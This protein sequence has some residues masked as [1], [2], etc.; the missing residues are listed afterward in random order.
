MVA[1]AL[2][3]AGCRKFSVASVEEGVELREAGV[4]GEI[5]VLLGAL[6]GEEEEATARSL[7][8]LLH[9]RE[10]VERWRAH[11]RLT[12]R[13]LPCHVKV[14]TGMNRAGLNFDD[15]DDIADVLASAP[16]IDVRGLATHMASSEDFD[17][18]AAAE[19]EKR[20][21]V[22]VAALEARGLRPPTAHMANSAAAVWRPSTR[23]DMVRSGLALYGYVGPRTPP[24]E[25]PQAKFE[26]ALEWRAKVL[27]VR[28]VAAGD[29]LGYSGVYTAT[30]PGRIA[31]ISAGY[32]DG[33]RRELSGAGAVSVGGVRRPMRG[34]V[35][36][37]SVLADVSEPPG[38]HAGDAA[39]LLGDG[40]DAVAL[41]EIC[42]TIPYEILCGI[43][44]RVARIHS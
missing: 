12:G 10:L 41:A 38:V 43:S 40:L 22:L 25:K 14:N 44:S 30:A 4:E 34:R 42:G 15:P 36:M 29:R 2:Q 27:D 5:L 21:A 24:S 8:P 13:R 39:V 1:R 33:L 23:Y 18:P 31:L 16:E 28:D 17:D 37:D 32:A 3:R 19:Q 20:F 26:P 7:T 6:P 35:S 9:S 11:A